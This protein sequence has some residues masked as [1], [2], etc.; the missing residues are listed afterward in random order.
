MQMLIE[1][2]RFRQAKENRF[3]SLARLESGLAQGD[4]AA[5]RFAA[6]NPNLVKKKEPAP[7]ALGMK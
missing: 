6:A 1:L 2:G 7:P 4:A 3:F 5:E